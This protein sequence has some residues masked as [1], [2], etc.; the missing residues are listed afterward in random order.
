MKGFYIFVASIS[1]FAG[2][3]VFMGKFADKLTF[4]LVLLSVQ[5]V[6]FYVVLDR[7]LKMWSEVLFFLASYLSCLY[8]VFSIFEMSFFDAFIGLSIIV[9]SDYAVY[10]KKPNEGL[11]ARKAKARPGL[12]VILFFSLLGAPFMVAL[13]WSMANYYNG[14]RGGEE[15]I[16]FSL[17]L[18]GVAFIFMKWGV[19]RFLEVRR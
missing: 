16:Y 4:F 9:L 3:Q 5:V 14:E 17:L 2:V 7:N 12:G 6:L 8:L 19:V 18:Y 15:A 1:M 10:K 11:R 13:L